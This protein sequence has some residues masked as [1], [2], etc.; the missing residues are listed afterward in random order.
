MVLKEAYRYQ[1]YLSDLL[2]KAESHLG[3]PDNVLLIQS[4]HLRSKTRAD[5]TDETTNN[6]NERSLQVCADDYV[7]FAMAVLDEKTE[8]SRAI[9]SAKYAMCADL[10]RSLA[11]NRARQ[12]LLY[13]LRGMLTYKDKRE[14]VT[15]GRANCFNVE[16]NEVSYS[17]DIKETTTIDFDREFVRGT[18]DSLSRLS[19]EVSINADRS[20]ATVEVSYQPRFNINNTFE[21]E[22]MKFVADLA[23]N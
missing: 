6:L 10:D 9:D 15:R 11:M 18:F 13:T 14:R 16:G 3:D 20:M 7:R 19:D 1:N 2:A 4:E 5:A 23:N 22:I 21:D 8:V 12:K 17:Y